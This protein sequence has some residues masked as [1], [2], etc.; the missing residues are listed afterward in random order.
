MKT[1]LSA[2]LILAAVA[3][4][5]VV[6]FLLAGDSEFT[7]A[8]G[9]A[10]E[11]IARVDPDYEPWFSPLLSLPGE[12]ETMLFSL[13]AA[14]GAGVIAFAFGYWV[15]LRK[16]NMQ[17]AEAAAHQEGTSGGRLAGAPGE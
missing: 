10:E 14:L 2:L 9:Q 17:H 1:W 3:V 12:T 5:M 7:G 6:P 13:Q 8:D 11:V 4:L 15:G 16:G